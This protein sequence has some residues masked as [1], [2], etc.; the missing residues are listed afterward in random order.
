MIR[1]W[2]SS[3][4][5]RT[6]AVLLLGLAGSNLAGFAFYWTDRSQ[7]LA[8]SRAG[9]IAG[10]IISVAQT[11]E[12]VPGPSRREFVRGL[13]GTGIRAIWT[14]E[15]PLAAQDRL[16]PWAASLRSALAREM[17]KEAKKRIKVS[18]LELEDLERFGPLAGPHE[19][20]MRG[21]PGMGRGSGPGGGSGRGLGRLPGVP[22]LVTAVSVELTDGSWLNFLTPTFGAK[23]FWSSSI[24]LPM[25]GATLAVILISVLAVWRATA[26]LALFTRAAERLGRDVNAPAMAEKGPGEVRRAARSFN[27]MQGRLQNFVADRTQMLAAI[28]HDL[29][30]PITRMKLR[31]EFVDDEEQRRKMLGDLDEMEA[32]IAATLSFARDDAAREERE[33]LDLAQLLRSLCDDYSGDQGVTYVGAPLALKRVFANLIGN[34]VKYG[35]T[36]KVSLA[37]E[38]NSIVITV[39]DDG[40]GIPEEECEKVFTAFYRLEHSRSRETGGVG[41]GL[42]VVRSIVRAHGGDVML[43]NRAEGGLRATV[44][45]PTA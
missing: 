20:M 33:P 6:V 11:V 41:L 23:P 8:E 14:P 34:A 13:H 29:R 43:S 45:L 12:E 5:G 37:E 24:F 19:T 25:L 3:L 2:P 32:M 10:Q 21:M 39:D 40:P 28:S 38:K 30:T 15:K 42:A 35:G 1:V 27:E 17:G 7:S 31:A 44:T 26:P 36:A 4:V 22:R 9:Q 18:I 16:S